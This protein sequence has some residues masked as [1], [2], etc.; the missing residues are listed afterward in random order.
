MKVRRFKGRIGHPDHGFGYLPDPKDHRYS[1]FHA[2]PASKMQALADASS[3]DEYAPPIWDQDGTASCLG[4]GT[5]GAI[6]TTF[7]ARGLALRCPVDPA[8]TYKLARAIDRVNAEDPLRDVGAYPNSMVRA[9]G[10]WGLVLEDEGSGRSAAAPDYEL[11]LSEHVNDELKLGV[12]EAAHDRPQPD[13]NALDGTGTV[14]RDQ[15]CAAIDAGYAVMG[16]VEAGSPTFQNFNGFG[17]LTYCGDEPDHWVY[18][19]KQRLVNGERQIFL[20]N[21]WGTG[22]WTPDGCAWCGE[23]FITRGLFNC[24][25]LNP[26]SFQ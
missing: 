12:L 2:H 20:R 23:D 26:R 19:T 13:F 5:A 14:L 25:I 17:I 7:A 10:L 21:S 22:L 24:L 9:L 16:A 11:Y 15:V 4:H 6:T 18:F 1:G 8:A 3:V